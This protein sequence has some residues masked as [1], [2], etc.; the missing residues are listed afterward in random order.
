MHKVLLKENLLANNAAARPGCTLFKMTFSVR[1]ANWSVRSLKRT[2]QYLFPGK[3]SRWHLSEF[4]RTCLV[5][6][7]WQP[8][9]ESATAMACI[10]C[11]SH[12]SLSA[13]KRERTDS[14]VFSIFLFSN[15]HV[16]MHTLREASLECD[17]LSIMKMK[18]PIA[19][20]WNFKIF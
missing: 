2:A 12:L 15:V 6:V 14:T 20:S 16:C 13:R 8:G 19:K 7:T 9:E 18:I 17:I 1:C 5:K 4:H 11:L 3:P 10:H